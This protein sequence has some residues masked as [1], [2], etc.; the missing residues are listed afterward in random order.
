[1]VELPHGATLGGL[2]VRLVIVGGL[3]PGPQ[4]AAKIRA[5]TIKTNH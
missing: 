4:A 5:I 3:F 2:A 1:M